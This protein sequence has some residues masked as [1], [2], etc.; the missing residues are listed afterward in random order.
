M[1]LYMPK[2]QHRKEHPTQFSFT[3]YTSSGEFADIYKK[4]IRA[5]NASLEHICQR[6][7]T[8]K[9]FALHADARGNILLASHISSQFDMK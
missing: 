7:K 6:C 2:V 8:R 9:S 1:V 3:V 5:Q 4:R